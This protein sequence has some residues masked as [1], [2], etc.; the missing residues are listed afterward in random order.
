MYGVYGIKAVRTVFA[1]F[2]LLA[3][4]NALLILSMGT[5]P[6]QATAAPIAAGPGAA[7]VQSTR[8]LGAT[9]SPLEGGHG[10]TVV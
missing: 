6:A 9:S 10:Q 8:P 2:I 7:G 1:G 3:A 4:S 5:E